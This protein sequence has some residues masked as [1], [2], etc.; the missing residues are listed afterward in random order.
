MAPDGKRPGVTNNI[1]LFPLITIFH[2]CYFTL[3]SN[4]SLNPLHLYPSD[5]IFQFLLFMHLIWLLHLLRCYSLLHT[6]CT[7]KRSALKC[8]VSTVSPWGWSICVIWAQKKS[9]GLVLHAS[10]SLTLCW[11]QV[12]AMRLSFVGELGWE[13]HIPKDSCIPVYKAVM[14]AGAK[15]GIINSGYR[16]IDSLSIEKGIVF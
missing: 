9:Q 13:L 1:N 14:A 12:R 8:M 2:L 11:L 7:P 16:A 6:S 10:L 15:H 4:F 5:M 3:H